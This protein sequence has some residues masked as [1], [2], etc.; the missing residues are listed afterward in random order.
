[1]FNNIASYK[2]V[3]QAIN[4]FGYNDLSFTE[5][6]QNINPESNKFGQLYN[7]DLNNIFDKVIKG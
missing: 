3:I 1:M 4:F 5:F 2:S 6:Y 7:I